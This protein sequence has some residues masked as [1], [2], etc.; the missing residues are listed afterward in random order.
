MARTAQAAAV[1]VAEPV[2]TA[3]LV[4]VATPIVDSSTTVAD[5]STAVADGE[6]KTPEKVENL[7][8]GKPLEN[9]GRLLPT[10]QPPATTQQPQPMNIRDQPQATRTF[11][12]P[13]KTMAEKPGFVY[14]E[15]KP[16]VELEGELFRWQQLMT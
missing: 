15:G 13:A 16:A 14:I 5:N 10:N 9:P 2:K 1:A 7:P 11:K 12:Q 6:L 8:I 4:P 3:T